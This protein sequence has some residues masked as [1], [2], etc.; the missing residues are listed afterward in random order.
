MILFLVLLTATAA[1]AVPAGDA[2]L[3]TRSAD[4]YEKP[5]VCAACHDDFYRQ[6]EQSMMSQ[7]YTHHWDEI[8][9][10]GL[11][12]PHAERDEKVAGVKAGCNGCHAPIAFLSG[13]VPPPRPGE[14]SRADEGVSCDLCHSITGFE[15]D[16]PYN[17]NW[18]SE[19]GRLKQGPKPGLVSPHHDTVE[20]PFLRTADFCGTCH[21]EMSPYG[22]WVKSTHLEW[23]E[24]PY[25]A[26]GVPCQDCHMPQAF[27]RN[28]KMAEPGMVAQHLFHGA[29]DEGK[30]K[31]AIEL[32]MH[33][34]ERE[35]EIDGTAVIR[36]QLFNGKCGHKVPSGSVED[37]ILWLHVEAIDSEGQVFHLPVDPKGF[38]GEETTIGSDVLAYQ[39]MGIPLDDPDF[40]GL[41]RDGDVPVGD[42]I[43]RMAYL[44]PQ[45]RVTIQ[46]WNTADFGPDYRIGPRETKLENFTW[47]LPADLAPGRVEVRA[48]LT[49]KRLVQS[50]ADFLEVPADETAPVVINTA[51]TWFEAYE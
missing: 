26:Q 34:L 23:R 51:S 5:T 18:I 33:P 22:K 32:R 16:T 17:F 8:E 38:A 4:D 40:A 20:N 48:V 29:H 7:A 44:D 6:W 43:F 25:A 14:G 45:G 3:G 28:A 39:D 9:Y 24:G 35:L 1:G 30:L 10:F 31:G 19:P 41:R 37:R 27:G 2:A 12:V 42:R 47:E 11:A 50:V 15:G 21:N 49:Y 46:Q 36:V 13:D